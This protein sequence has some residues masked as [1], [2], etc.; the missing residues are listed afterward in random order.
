MSKKKEIDVDLSRASR[1]QIIEMQAEAYYRALKRVEE[2]KKREEQALY[3]KV[4]LKWYESI[5]YF[6]NV[7][8]CPW[9]LVKRFSVK[10]RTYDLWLVW[11]VSFALKV[12]GMFLWGAGFI[13]TVY[14]VIRMIIL[15]L[16]M[17]RV[18]LCL[19]GVSAWL[20]GSITILA[21]K[22]FEK[23]YDG[24][25]IYAFSACVLAILSCVLSVVAW[26]L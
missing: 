19:I 22:T 4:K 23:E 21:G 11:A 7:L 26:F 3:S 8:I 6:V 1:E 18:G 5:L 14:G 24:N 10:E 20:F 17:E 16:Y 9:R 2:E 12:V 25:R 15:R 13:A